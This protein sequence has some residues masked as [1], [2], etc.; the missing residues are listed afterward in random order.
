CN[1]E[2]CL[3]TLEIIASASTKIDILSLDI[4]IENINDNQPLFPT[5]TFQ[6]RL[7]E[8]TDL[9]YVASFPAAT[10]LDFQD[11]LEYRIVPLDISYKQETLE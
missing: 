6:I 4:I 5:S 3:L 10:D 2:R 11:R 8:N 1:C 9:G 7:S